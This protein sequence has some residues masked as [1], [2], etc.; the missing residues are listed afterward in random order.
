MSVIASA[1]SR[2]SRSSG[3]NSS[4]SRHCGTASIFPREMPWV[5][6]T[7]YPKSMH[8]GQP[9]L[10]AAARS[11]RS[12]IFTSNRRQRGARCSNWPYA[13]ATCGW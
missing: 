2:T 10:T 8:H 4:L 3:S 11:A 7:Q 5:C 12:L 1:Y 9:I 13:L 6:S